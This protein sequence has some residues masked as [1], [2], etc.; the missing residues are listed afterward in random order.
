MDFTKMMRTADLTAEIREAGLEMGFDAVGFARAEELTD[1]GA[2]LKNWLERGFHGEMKWLER[3]PERRSDPRVH[4]EGARSV[5][6][7]ALNYYTPAEHTYRSETGKISRYAWGDDYHE[8]MKERL[9]ALLAHIRKISPEA[10]GMVCVDTSAVMDKAWAV[11]SG[12]GWLGK[13]SNV[14][15]KDLGSWIFL[16]EIIL[17]IELDYDTEP[18]PDHCGTC[19]ACI[20]ACPT[21]A[22]VEPYVVDSRKCISYATIEFRDESLPEEIADNLNGWLY[23][24]DICQDVCPWNRFEKPATELRFAPRDGQTSLDLKK[25]TRMEHPEYSQRFRGSAIKRA[26]LAGLKR[27]ASALLENRKRK[28]V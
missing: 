21:G 25:I 12:I 1:E 17:D 24:C 6:S 13:H 15:S 23:G 28:P 26:K 9:Y 10:R 4:F 16:G 7:V 14:I 5:V 3:E 20:D 22:I 19:T 2:D 8:V 27:N 11:R 18:V